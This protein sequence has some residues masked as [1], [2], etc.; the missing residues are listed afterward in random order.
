MLMRAQ[1]PHPDRRM[2]WARGR[3]MRETS[4]LSGEGE[5]GPVTS[6]SHWEGQHS[7]FYCGDKGD[8]RVQVPSSDVGQDS[9]A[10]RR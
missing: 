5:Q 1:L 4:N 6:Q 7:L 10:T 2:T 3:G 9:D 8:S